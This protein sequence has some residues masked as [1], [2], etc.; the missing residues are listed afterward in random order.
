MRIKQFIL[1]NKYFTICVILIILIGGFIILQN[2]S[3][4]SVF[5]SASKRK[6]PI[7][8]V[9]TDKKQLSISFDAAWENGKGGTLILLG[10]RIL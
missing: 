6:L 7:Y 2:V 5:N 10:F 8:C 1:N 9:E 3:V 4:V